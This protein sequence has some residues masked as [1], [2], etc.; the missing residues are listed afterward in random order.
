MV[1]LTGPDGVNTDFAPNK[2]ETRSS[3]TTKNTITLV[4]TINVVAANAMMISYKNV[5][6]L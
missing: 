3:I 6:V 1:I 5:L 2:I 4:N